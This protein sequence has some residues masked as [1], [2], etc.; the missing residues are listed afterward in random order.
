MNKYML[1][2]VLFLFLCISEKEKKL[3]PTDVS[4]KKKDRKRWKY[5]EIYEQKLVIEYIIND[6]F[7][8][9]SKRYLIK[10]VIYQKILIIIK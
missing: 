4:Y 9:S 5:K 3:A 8:L 10:F 6:D 2:Q 7:Y 1:W